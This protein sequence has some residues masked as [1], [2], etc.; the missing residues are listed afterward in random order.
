MK[1]RAFINRMGFYGLSNDGL[2]MVLKI[3]FATPS[4]T[5]QRFFMS[6]LEF[7]PRIQDGDTNNMRY[8]S[9]KAL[10]AMGCKSWRRLNRI[11][12]KMYVLDV[13]GVEIIRITP[14]KESVKS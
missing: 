12:G 1:I 8:R 10:C 14:I 3:E 5:R 7:S 13:L 2:S 11:F 9:M 6:T 4:I